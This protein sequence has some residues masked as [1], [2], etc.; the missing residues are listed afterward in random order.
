[1]N[2][3]IQIPAVLQSLDD[4]QDGRLKAFLSKC[5]QISLKQLSL[6]PLRT[7]YV[8]NKF[9]FINIVEELSLRGFSFH[10]EKPNNI[11]PS[12]VV[13]TEVVIY[14]PD[15]NGM[16]QKIDYQI[17]GL[18]GFNQRFKVDTDQFFHY[19]PIEGFKTINRNIDLALLE[20]ELSKA[21][22]NLKEAASGVINETATPFLPNGN[23]EP[24]SVLEDVTKEE[25][26]GAEKQI[27]ITE[28]FSEDRFWMFRNF[29]SRIGITYI[30]DI[31]PNHLEEH[32]RRKGVSPAK[33]NQV[34]ERLNKL[35][36]KESANGESI[37]L[38]TENSIDVVFADNQ[39]NTFRKY[40]K[41]ASIQFVEEITEKHLGGYAYQLGVGVGKVNA[42]EER[43]NLFLS[44]GIRSDDSVPSI[45]IEDIFTDFKYRSFFA[46]C[47]QKGIKTIN[48]LTDSHFNEYGMMRGVGV[49]KVK[50]VKEIVEKRLELHKGLGN[51]E[52]N[53][54]SL[55][56]IN[57]VFH[58]NI[59]RSFRM[60]CAD[61]S[62]ESIFDIMGQHLLDFKNTKGVGENRVVAVEKRL[63]AEL[64]LHQAEGVFADQEDPLSV[65]LHAA[66]LKIEE[67]FMERKYTTFRHYCEFRRIATLGQ[68]T[69]EHLYD[70]S[71][72][73][74]VGKKK[75][76]DVMKVLGL[77]A[78][79]KSDR[80]DN[81]FQ[82]G[83][84][85]EAIKEIQVQALF[86][87]YGFQTK[88]TSLL[89]IKE[90]EGKELSMLKVEF[91]PQLLMSLS[92]LL[93]KQK[94]PSAII[95]NM[96]TNLPDRD[97][98]IIMHRY[99]MGMTLDETGKQFGV[100][101]ER[102]RQ[103]AKKAIKKM[104]AY[105]KRQHFP[106]IVKVLSPHEAFITGDQFVELVG[107]EFSFIVGLLKQENILLD[108]YDR[109]GIF[110]LSDVDKKDLKQVEGFFDDLPVV[111]SA[112]DFHQSLE[113]IL[114][115]I[116]I[117]NPTEEML[118]RMFEKERYIRYGE[119]YSRS[120]LSMNQVLNYMFEHHIKEPLRVDEEGAAYLQQLAKK[121]LAYNLGT[122]L[123]SIDARIRDTE[124]VI[125]VNS[126]TFQ[127]FDSESF[128]VEFISQIED[129]L[130]EQFEIKEVVNT[131][132]IY[133]HFHRRIEKLGIISKLHLYSLI[134]YYLDDKF[135]IGKGNT[136]NIFRNENAKLSREDSLIEY[137]KKHGGQC[138]K[139]QLLEVMKPLYKIDLTVGQSDQLIPWGTNSVI[140]VE[141]LNF[142]ET[143]LEQLK[144]FFL[145][146]FE[147]GFTTVNKLYKD[148]VFDRKLSVLLRNKGIDEPGKLP[149]IIKKMIPIV[150][151][152]TN[153]LY[154]DGC[155]YDSVDKVIEDKFPGETSRQEIRDLLLEYGYKEIMVGN[156]MK[157]I[158]NHGLFTEVDFNVLYPSK[159]FEVTDEVLQ[160]IKAFSE[161][162]QGG[163]AYIAIN[164]LKGYRRKLPS[165]QFRW[166]P[167]L[168][169]SMLELCGYRQI[170]KN[171]SDYRYDKLIVVKEN[172]PL[173]TFENLVLYIL[174]NEYTGNMHEISI[175]DYLMA[176]GIVREQEYNHKKV[177]PY[178]IR[179]SEKL[180]FDVLGYVTVKK[181][182]SHVV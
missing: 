164:N 156:I 142:S 1:M 37:N 96:N 172:S 28:A 128:D 135:I 158:M 151:G 6:D 97:Y 109:L 152:H 127:Y 93:M 13:S 58:E 159:K 19:V 46:F 38:E 9:E 3:Y 179:N 98:S 35:L 94:T 143:E 182:D 150:K 72:Q 163:K 87:N 160:E 32:K 76:E 115:T 79:N 66:N 166:N 86:Y 64:A 116:G 70:Y 61:H 145:A 141:K 36:Q 139:N 113:E 149:A 20:K 117:E 137:M 171:I 59:Y 101:R 26:P 108:Y 65:G 106:E 52:H 111:F 73:P 74:K 27:K 60:F 99:G 83:E 169:T 90:I 85:F 107:S 45:I 118:Q 180:E 102:V 51:Q 174:E 136:L 120:R 176:N 92:Q 161:E 21:G 131:E 48:E 30:T 31:S 40:C 144:Q 175:Y 129:Y 24:K 62:I 84:I 181:G 119:V 29:C 41:E 130:N 125:L 162:V 110:F 123:R 34:K 77:Y 153:F 57:A 80:T 55:T 5:Q 148:M 43:L 63:S 7:L 132:E 22:F 104:A 170:K 178:E 10:T 91:E 4:L 78:D 138:T 122:T 134:R 50:V 105:L 112:T 167:F 88:S 44:G 75:F 177:L 53:K 39:Y 82:S 68:I 11:L 15:N 42:I 157:R 140:L 71:K 100:S 12:S 146:G 49:G 168:L 47:K 147:E 173:K 95:S 14:S 56:S 165:I 121:H 23:E 154:L 8:S 25:E 126:S 81:L 133:E 33:F 2:D 18:S 114:Q 124:D 155:K 54:Q 17:L 67:I 103:V 69:S 89:T 16:F